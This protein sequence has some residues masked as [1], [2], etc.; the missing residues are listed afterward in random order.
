MQLDAGRWMLGPL[1]GVSPVYAPEIPIISCPLLREPE[2][3]GKVTRTQ[4]AAAPVRSRRAEKLNP[5]RPQT[6]TNHRGQCQLR[7]LAWV[8]PWPWKC[9]LWTPHC[10]IPHTGQCCPSAISGSNNNDKSR[11]LFQRK[12]DG[13]KSW[14]SR[15]A[16]QT[17]S[18]SSSS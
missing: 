11:L 17:T 14:F 5:L 15:H 12:G 8:P 10:P 1:A 18:S 3:P 16:L 2:S 7:T 9:Q 13:L 6:P 4:I